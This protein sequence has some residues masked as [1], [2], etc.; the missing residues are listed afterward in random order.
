MSKARGAV[1]QYDWI[2]MGDWD[3]LSS[4]SAANY[5]SVYLECQE[6]LRSC[7]HDEWHS[8]TCWCKNLAHGCFGEKPCE[9]VPKK[10]G[11]CIMLL[12]CIRNK[13][14][15]PS[16]SLTYPKTFLW[17]YFVLMNLEGSQALKALNCFIYSLQCWKLTWGVF[18]LEIYSSRPLA[19][20][21][22]PRW[23]I[24]GK[25]ARE[26][27]VTQRFAE[28]QQTV[29]S[30]EISLWPIVYESLKPWAQAE[31]I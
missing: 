12:S 19:A 31:L 21:R 29:V 3:W 4:S 26:L 7:S 16:A 15:M 20:L 18:S 6:I 17:C 22:C 11:K 30:D 25:I 2:A 8:Q 5:P 24:I 27:P 13:S 28:L 23:P 9:N 14:W 1:R 10:F